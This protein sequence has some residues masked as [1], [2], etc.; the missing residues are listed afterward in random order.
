MI[1]AEYLTKLFDNLCG[2][3]FYARCDEPTAMVVCHGEA[4]THQCAQSTQEA[5]DG[6]GQLE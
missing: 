1:S 5:A 4:G 2:E 3:I 6:L